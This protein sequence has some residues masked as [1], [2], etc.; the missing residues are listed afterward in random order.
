VLDE[1][2]KPIGD[3]RH[4]LDPGTD[5]RLIA[6]CMLRRHQN[7]RSPVNGFGGSLKYPALKY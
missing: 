1:A 7:A 4:H 5:A 6:C 3:E 2:G